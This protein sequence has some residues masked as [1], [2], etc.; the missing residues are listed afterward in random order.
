MA[1]TLKDEA[2]TADL[3]AAIARSLKRGD[4]VLLKG[5]LGSGKTTLA[6]AILRALGVREY[7]PSPSFTMMQSYET[8]GLTVRHFDLFRIL[9]S[10]ELQELGI[11]DALLEGA[12]LVEWPERAG[13]LEPGEA[14]EIELAA[15]GESSRKATLRGPAR[16]HRA[17]GGLCQ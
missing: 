1:I 12:V 17:L 10:G 4:A 7:I 9:G 8:P 14:L 13:E 5:E 3:G 6:R 15:T 2:A 11:D 16:W